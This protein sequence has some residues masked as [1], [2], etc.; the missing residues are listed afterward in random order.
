MK[1]L[2]RKELRL[3][4]N[5]LLTWMGLVFLLGIFTYFEYLSMKDSLDE[6]VVIMNAYPRIMMILFGIGEGLG[7]VLSWYGCIYFWVTILSYSYAA[8]LGLS[9]VAKEKMQGTAEYLFTRPVNRSQ[10]VMAKTV[11]GICNLFI[12]AAFCGLSNYV[13]FIMHLG[14][15]EQNSILITTTIGMFLT[16]IVIFALMLLL[17]GLT[18]TY[19]KAVRLGTGM[20]LGFY[21][22]YVAAEYLEIPA[23]FY[24]TPIK[25]FDVYAVARDGFQTSF[26]LISAVIIIGSVIKAQKLWGK[27]EIS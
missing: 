9:C 23:L 22:L 26:L 10:I 5:L 12:L 14:G 3:T 20:L 2:I 19:R 7:S 16:E 15:L 21:V 4:R 17:S 11:A 13:S 24:L 8:Y 27:R 1:V 6:L 18:R 25:Y